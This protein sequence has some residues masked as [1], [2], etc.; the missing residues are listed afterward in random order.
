MHIL[1]ASPY[2]PWPLIE[3]GRVAQYRTFE[4]LRDACTFTL[5]VPV[6]NLEQETNA[7]YFAAKF[8]NITVAAVRCFPLRT[9][10]TLRARLRRAG[11]KLFRAIFP[12]SKVSHP[13]A[14]ATPWYPFG[15]LP[16]EYV[17]AVEMHFAKGCDIFQAEF[18][19]MMTLGP[20]MAGR[21]PTLFVHH[22]LHYVYAQRFIETNKVTGANARYLAQRMAAEESAYLNTFDAAV[23]F[24]EVDRAALATFCPQLDVQVSPFPTPE[25]P[26]TV[27]AVI[28][29]PVTHFVFVASEYHPNVDGFRWFLKEVWPAIRTRVPGAVIEVIGKWSR[30]L[31]VSLP[32]WQEVQF[33]GFVPDLGKALTNKIMIVPLWIGSGIRTKILAAWGA[34]CPVITTTVGVEGLPGNNGEHFVVADEAANFASA[35]IE[36]SQNVTQLN[37]LAANGLEQ[38]YKHYS[39]TAVRE[40]RLAVYEKLMGGRRSP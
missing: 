8:P 29:H 2:L 35:C 11:G 20:L 32:N 14:E 7:K 26:A 40:Q 36:L 16:P 3:G 5:V 6:Y 23:V 30:S 39:L 13:S 25:D 12:P 33:T 34:S 28:N 19:E 37:Q 27:V 1:I 9:S 38:V 21:V 15:C 10:T 31:Q 22:Q 18:A 24:S 4:A 17:A